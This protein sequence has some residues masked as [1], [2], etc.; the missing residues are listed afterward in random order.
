MSRHAD[1]RHGAVEVLEQDRGHR[2]RHRREPLDH[3]VDQL[4]GE[5][6]REARQP[7]VERARR[8]A[9]VEDRV[10]HRV[11][12][13]S[14][15]DH[16]R[17]APRLERR[18]VTL[19]LLRV[20]GVEDDHARR[21]SC[22]SRRARAR[23]RRTRSGRR[24]SRQRRRGRSGAGPGAASIGCAIKPPVTISSGCR[25]YVKVVATPKLP[26]P[27]RS[28]Q[29]RSGSDASVTSST[30]PSAVTSST[31]SRLSA[32]RPC[33]AISQ[34]S[35]PPSV[36]PGDAGR[37]DRAAGDGEA[38][39]GRGVVQLAPG[40]DRPRPAPCA[41]ARRRRC[42]SS[43]RGRSSPRRRRPRGRRRCARR[44]ERRCRGRRPGRSA[45]RRRRRPRVRQRTITAGARSTR[46]LW[47]RRAAS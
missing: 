4:V 41:P 46:P 2:R 30:S 17:R 20:A 29:K 24:S 11:R 43:R 14:D 37:R 45:R 5:P 10:H 26:P 34:P 9:G 35:P 27:P 47:T 1:A 31:A 6:A 22:P 21:A 44:R 7:V 28:A 18:E 12:H 15:L 25:R 39:L 13:P 38:V 3:R 32:A 16:Q 19:G 40:R 23:A 42:P 36:Q 8:V 33:F